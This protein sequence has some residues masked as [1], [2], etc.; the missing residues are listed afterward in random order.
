MWLNA[1]RSN[2]RNSKSWG[3][4]WPNIFFTYLPPPVKG[5]SK[6]FL[7]NPFSWPK[8]YK[9][10]SWGKKVIIFF[11]Y[12]PLS[13]EGRSKKWKNKSLGKKSGQM[14]RVGHKKGSGRKD[15]C[16]VP[17]GLGAVAKSSSLRGGWPIS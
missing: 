3:K 16:S 13:I 5:R 4:K 7:F 9:S 12:L 1:G 17:P 14:S 10:K 6:K 2:K 15:H 8:K 11:T